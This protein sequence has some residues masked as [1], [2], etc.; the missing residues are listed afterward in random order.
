[1]SNVIPMISPLAE[2][3][4]RI[5]ALGKQTVANVIE[6]GKLLT[7]CRDSPHMK[8]GEWLPWLHH[9]FGWKQ[10]TAY[11]FINIYEMTTKSKVANFANLNLDISALYLLAA[12]GNADIREE[13]IEEVV[14]ATKATGQRATH[15]TVKQK[16]QAVRERRQ[17]RADDKTKHKSKSKTRPDSKPPKADDRGRLGSVDIRMDPKVWQQL[18]EM[19]RE[20]GT[21]RAGL[22]NEILMNAASQPIDQPAAL[23][24]WDHDAVETIAKKLVDS[25]RHKAQRLYEALGDVLELKPI[26]SGE[27]ETL[28][29]LNQVIKKFVP[30]FERVKEQGTKHDV[31]YSKEELRVIVSTAQKIMDSW[32]IGDESIRRVRGHVVSQDNP[33][34]KKGGAQ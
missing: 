20:A 16:A 21:T 22:A 24:D 5:R 29:A 26:R 7:E 31:Y 28:I 30:L 1:M 18:D 12:P 6:I 8:H 13:V 27:T 34:T 10:R 25:K 9:E 19:A 4:N 2:K 14:A 32:A 3:A 15:Q 11:N 23:F 17:P 33:V